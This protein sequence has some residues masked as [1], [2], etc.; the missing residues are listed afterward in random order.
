EAVHFNAPVATGGAAA[1]RPGGGGGGPMGGMGGLPPMSGPGAAPAPARPGPDAAEKPHAEAALSEAKDMPARDGRT[2]GK[3][4]AGVTEDDTLSLRAQQALKELNDVD[5][6]RLHFEN[7]RTKLGLV[8]QLYRKL[9]P[10]MGWAENNYYKLPIAQ[11]VAGLVPV[12]PFWADY[13]R[14]ADGPFLS[15]HL[16]DASRNFT[17]MMFALAV[18]DLPFESPKHQVAFDGPKMTLTPAG[19]V[20]AFHEEVR[21][22]GDPDGKVPVLV[23]QNYY[24]PTDRFREENGERVDKYVT[25]EF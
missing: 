5:G 6:E 14:H 17:E 8:R 11:Q 9:D 13:A 1:G 25:G 16:A 24:R 19:P 22:A 3:R 10:T 15:R 21:A 4:R 2:A 7:D 18:L 12:G 20:V 23:G